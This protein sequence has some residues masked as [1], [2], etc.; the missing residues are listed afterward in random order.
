M[1]EPDTLF[2]VHVNEYGGDEPPELVTIPVLKWTKLY[3]WVRMCL[4]TRYRTRIARAN[5][6]TS[7]ADTPLGAWRQFKTRAEN[8][9]NHHEKELEKNN[10]H[11][12]LADA[13]V[14]ELS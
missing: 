9:R 6:T 2:R 3:A 13:K 8:S 12:A 5:T 4:A 14:A 7:Y 10:L 11:V 1:S